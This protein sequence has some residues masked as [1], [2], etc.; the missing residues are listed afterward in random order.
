MLTYRTVYARLCAMLFI[1]LFCSTAFGGATKVDLCHIPPGDPDNFHTISINEKAVPSHIRHGDTLGV[2]ED[3]EEPPVN[4]CT[5]FTTDT[6]AEMDKIDPSDLGEVDACDTDFDPAG[7]FVVIYTNG[8]F[9][10]SGTDCGGL[11][12]DCASIDSTGDAV[13]SPAEISAED[14]QACRVLLAAGCVTP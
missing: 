11:V 8:A 12:P 14:D 13:Y 7:T 4:L 9:A 5:C 2:C 3:I 6:A 10:C 1:A